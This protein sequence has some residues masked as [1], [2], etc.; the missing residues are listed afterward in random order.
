MKNSKDKTSKKCTHI[1]NIDATIY[2]EN[3][4]LEELNNGGFLLTLTQL[5]PSCIIQEK[6]KFGFK[7]NKKLFITNIIN[8][9]NRDIAFSS[10]LL[11]KG[12]TDNSKKVLIHS[13]RMANIALDILNNKKIV[14][15]DQN[16]LVEKTMDE[17]ND[18]LNVIKINLSSL[19]VS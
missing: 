10:K 4:F 19:V 18:E 5:V 9:I 12:N 14:I 3:T 16:T 2:D 13:L 1:A 7:L 11:L 17:I 15:L 8:E 6:K